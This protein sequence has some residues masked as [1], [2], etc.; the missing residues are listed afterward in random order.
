MRRMAQTSRHRQ[1]KVVPLVCATPRIMRRNVLHACNH[2][3]SADIA[4]QRDE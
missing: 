1:E 4:I 2:F 3:S